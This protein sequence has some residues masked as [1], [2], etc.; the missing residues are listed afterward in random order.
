MHTLLYRQMQTYRYTI[1]VSFQYPNEMNS[2]GLREKRK[3]VAVCKL[4][5]Q[6][7]NIVALIGLYSLVSA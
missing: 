7:L 1:A 2:S 5:R 6:L 3:H 4:L